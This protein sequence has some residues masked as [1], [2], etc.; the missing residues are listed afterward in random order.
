MRV[1]GLWTAEHG[2]EVELAGAAVDMA[3][4]LPQTLMVLGVSKN[5]AALTAIPLLLRYEPQLTP[6]VARYLRLLTPD[7]CN[8]VASVIS[9]C[10][11]ALT[12]TRWQRLWLLHVMEKV[13]L[14]AVSDQEALTSW[15]REEGRDALVVLRCQA[16]WSLANSFMLRREDWA[17]LFAFGGQYVTPYAAGSVHGIADLTTQQRAALAPTGVMEEVVSKWA[18]HQLA[19][20]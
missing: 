11:S 20:F 5:D 6:V 10:L 3:Q 2:D 17:N 9:G 14:S 1:I 19:P 16:S 4:V 18:H 12:L 15:M 8:E 7:L 13:P